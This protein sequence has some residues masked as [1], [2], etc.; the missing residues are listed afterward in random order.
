[1]GTIAGHSDVTALAAPPGTTI[2]AIA[3]EAA[4]AAAATIAANA[5]GVDNQRTEGCLAVRLRRDGSADPADLNEPTST[6]STSASL[7]PG[8]RQGLAFARTA[9]CATGSRRG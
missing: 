3:L 5:G 2:S 9:A 6:I 8:A 7:S 1:L 4:C